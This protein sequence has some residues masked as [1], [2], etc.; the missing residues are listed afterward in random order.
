MRAVR[1]GLVALAAVAALTVAAGACSSSSDKGSAPTSTASSSVAPE[2]VRAPDAQ[3]A[4]GLTQIK[5]I[6][7]QVAQLTATDKAT[8]KQVDDQ[9]E[10]AWE[11]IEGTVK[12]NDPDTYLTFEDSFADLEQAVDSGNAAKAQQT[13]STVSTTVDAYVAKHLG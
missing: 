10:P 8:A 11:Q 12:A 4:A 1:P 2:D 6:S 7:G 13:A 9:I 3:V 5:T